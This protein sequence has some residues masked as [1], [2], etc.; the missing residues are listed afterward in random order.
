M[1]GQAVVHAIEPSAWGTRPAALPGPGL[2]T[3][4][5]VAAAAVAGAWLARYRPGHR[6]SGWPPPPARCSSSRGS[7]TR[8]VHGLCVGRGGDRPEMEE[9][10]KT[11]ADVVPQAE[12]RAVTGHRPRERRR[13]R[14]GW[15]FAPVAGRVYEV[16]SLAVAPPLPAVAFPG[17]QGARRGRPGSCLCPAWHQGAG[18]PRLGVRAVAGMPGPAG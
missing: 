11:Q 15:M 9:T 4:G 18:H 16:C 6:R 12:V 8:F 1:K 17:R 2:V 3:A 7:G 10:R 14:P 13:A 5:L